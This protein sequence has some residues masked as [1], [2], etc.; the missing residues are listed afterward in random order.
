MQ[1]R[2]N[3][4]YF[5]LRDR[6]LN[7]DHYWWYAIQDDEE[8]PQYGIYPPGYSKSFDDVPD[9][10]CVD[11]NHINSLEI[12]VIFENFQRAFPL[13]LPRNELIITDQYGN[14]YQDNQT[15]TPDGILYMYDREFLDYPAIMWNLGPTQ[16]EVI[17]NDLL[18]IKVV[19][20]TLY[21]PATQFDDQI[22]N[23]RNR[24]DNYRLI[25]S[26]NRADVNIAHIL[27][28][29]FPNNEYPGIGNIVQE[30]VRGRR[31]VNEEMEEIEENGFC[32]I[33]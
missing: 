19:Q 1:N 18:E 25:E 10:L 17:S 28:Q 3:I 22:E 20:Y 24:R 4:R 16:F 5:A 27:D 32:N 15:H 33:L 23:L 31:G 14:V 26:I 29:R 30:M 12:S 11:Y 2:R 8:S 21:D 7:P 13:V 9:A 6:A